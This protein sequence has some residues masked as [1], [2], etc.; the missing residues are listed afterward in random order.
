MHMHGDRNFFLRLTFLLLPC[1]YLFPGICDK[2]C[3]CVCRHNWIIP[4]LTHTHTR[5]PRTHTPPPPRT[6]V[7][8][9][10]T[11]IHAHTWHM[12]DTFLK[13]LICVYVALSLAVFATTQGVTCTSTYI[14]GPSCDTFRVRK[15]W[16][17]LLTQ[18]SNLLFHL[19]LSWL[20]SRTF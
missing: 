20:W 18:L 15:S 19:R 2:K 17:L 13:S 14:G 1:R 3:V 5:P 12:I 8:H 6:H 4:C 10:R 7:P 9:A 11:H 16:L